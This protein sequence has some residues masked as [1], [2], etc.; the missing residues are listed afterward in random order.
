M[1]A[2][3]FSTG[4]LA[5]HDFRAALKMMEGLPLKALE[6]SALREHELDP[7]LQA[8][9]SLELDG[10]EHVSLHAPSALVSLSEAALCIKLK[11]L[12][13]HYPIVVHPDIIIDWALWSSLGA[14]VLIEN[15]D[16]RKCIGRTADELDLV[17]ER[18][19][20]ARLCLDVGHSRQID[21]SMHE[22]RQILKR[23]GARLAE[24]HLSDVNSACGHEC[25]NWPAV[26]AFQRL[27]DLVPENV[28]VIL[29]TPAGPGQLE[30]QLEFAKQIF[31][32]VCA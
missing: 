11:E 21:S 2:F 6:L 8:L 24:I 4:S 17:F 9:H 25:L 16:K 14:T 23:H 20:D 13:G 22:T 31:E 28:P 15:M 3:G 7:L 19:P 26:E 18:L 30:V 5:G 1:R 29:E 27:R 10:Y 12:G 32:L